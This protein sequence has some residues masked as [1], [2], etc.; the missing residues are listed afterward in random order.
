[1]VRLRQLSSNPALLKDN[2]AEFIGREINNSGYSFA[3]YIEKYNE[4][5]VS[6]KVQKAIEIAMKYILILLMVNVY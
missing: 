4:N 5:E 6:A 1:M 3:D 2:V